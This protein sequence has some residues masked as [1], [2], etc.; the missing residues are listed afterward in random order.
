MLLVVVVVVTVDVAVFRKSLWKKQNYSE[1]DLKSLAFRS[2][3]ISKY[4][5]L[6]A[7]IITA[8]ILASPKQVDFSTEL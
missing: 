3:R 5:K 1:M 6:F 4:L 8:A 2:F 7:R